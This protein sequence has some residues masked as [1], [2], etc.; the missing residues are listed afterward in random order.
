MT[1]TTYGNKVTLSKFVEMEVNDSGSEDEMDNSNFRTS[2]A[3]AMCA[4]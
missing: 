4:T 3:T 2:T 1:R